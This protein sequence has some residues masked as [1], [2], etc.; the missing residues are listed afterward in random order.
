MSVHRNKPAIIAVCGGSTVT[1]EYEMVSEKV[2]ELIAKEGW[3]LICGG[4]TGAME[5]ACKGAKRHGGT[6]IG[7]LP[8]NDTKDANQFVDI[9]IA[10][11]TGYQRN[12]VIVQTADAI[13]AIDGKEG[14]LSEIC[15][16]IV[17]KKIV[18]TIV[19]ERG[20][21][22]MGGLLKQHSSDTP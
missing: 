21:V 1:P 12:A 5:A 17:Y 22:D 16:A 20:L 8:G 7:I 2:G 11:G 4:L 10:T 18:V 9:P 13:I 6:T 15:Y 14:T 19:L 3:Y